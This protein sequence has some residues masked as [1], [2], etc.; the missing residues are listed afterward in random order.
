MF[1]H[2]PLLAGAAGL[3]GQLSDMVGNA[4]EQFGQT[5]RRRDHASVIDVAAISQIFDTQEHSP[6]SPAAATYHQHPLHYDHDDSL[7]EGGSITSSTFGPDEDT[8]SLSVS[9]PSIER[10][11]SYGINSSP[12]ELVWSNDLCMS[13]IYGQ[14]GRATLLECLVLSKVN[15]ERVAKELYRDMERRDLTNMFECGSDFSR[16]G[17]AM[18]YVRTLKTTEN[19]WIKYGIGPGSPFLQFPLLRTL[20]LWDP[21]TQRSYDD[22]GLEPALI[23]EERLSGQLL[24]IHHRPWKYSDKDFFETMVSQLVTSSSSNISAVTIG[25]CPNGSSTLPYPYTDHLVASLVHYVQVSLSA[26]FPHQESVFTNLKTFKCQHYDTLETDDLAALLSLC[27]KLV[28]LDVRIKDS[29]IGL[30]KIGPLLSSMSGTLKTVHL[31]GARIE[32]LSFLRNCH[33]VSLI[34]SGLPSLGWMRD[35]RDRAASSISE[36]PAL[37]YLTLQFGYY[38]S[39]YQSVLAEY[40]E[41][42]IGSLSEVTIQIRYDD[43]LSKKRTSELRSDINRLRR[44]KANR[45]YTGPGFRLIEPGTPTSINSNP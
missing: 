39:S 11:S 1:T 7:S 3:M 45:V 41:V 16:L 36:Q 9:T 40:L 26:G 17:V 20:E 4:W 35:A 31:N 15:V 33:R 34:F 44:I 19:E 25:R 10:P 2:N 5:I 6:S 29:T 27:P 21:D 32:W 14:M 13:E 8:A 24:L 12:A 28:E 22:Y 38:S 37:Q 42:S 23:V 30:N 18:R 43:K